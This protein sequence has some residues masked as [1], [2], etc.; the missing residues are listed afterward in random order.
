V[1]IKLPLTDRQ[2]KPIRGPVY[3][4][5]C[6]HWNILDDR[7]RPKRIYSISCSP[8]HGLLLFVFVFFFWSMCCLS[9]DL[10]LVITSLVFKCF[11]RTC[12][13]EFV[14]LFLFIRLVF[15]FNMVP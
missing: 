10:R 15:C 1:Y 6:Q 2:V 14:F 11:F 12:H 9:F 5:A 8:F 4:I 13:F 7:R 3:L